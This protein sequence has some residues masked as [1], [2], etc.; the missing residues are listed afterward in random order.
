MNQEGPSASFVE[1][2][3]SALRHLCDLP[4]LRRHPLPLQLEPSEGE[5]REP[6]EIQLCRALFA[7]IEV[8]A[9]AAGIPLGTPHARVPN[10]LRLCYVEGLTVPEA[11]LELGVSTRQAYRDLRHAEENVAAVLWS[12]RSA[13][14][15]TTAVSSSISAEVDRLQSHPTPVDAL[16]LVRSALL[17]VARL[18]ERHGVALDMESPSSPLVVIAD[19]VLAQQVTVG[20]LS[21]AVQQACPGDMQIR[22]A[23]EREC[24][25][26]KLVYELRPELVTK[27]TPDSITLQ[28]AGRLGWTLLQEDGA[29]NR[30]VITLA[31]TGGRPLLLIINDD[32]GLAKLV[33]QFLTGH[34]CHIVAAATGPQGVRLARELVPDAILLEV[35][36]PE[37]DGWEVL[38]T[39]RNQKETDRIPVIICS[40][41]NDPELA[42]SLGAS[43]VLANPLS[44]MDL[45][46]ALRSLRV[47]E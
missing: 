6:A 18:A 4:W 36:I 45:V 16:L 32:E 22:I 9:P 39:L 20:I 43:D 15:S 12:R 44:Q 31:M 24:V 10:L 46:M 25:L 3:R 34:N 37:V 40:V 17:S 11:A 41:V 30:R 8:L 35:M 13:D 27:G 26:M 21:R 29:A 2:V 14:L 47:L 19:P 38:R 23:A 33:D 7:G 1:A 28:L 42:L 5:R